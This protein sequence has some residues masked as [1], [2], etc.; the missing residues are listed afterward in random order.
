MACSTQVQ[1]RRGNTADNAGFTGVVGEVTYDTQT[2][3]LFTHD[4]ATVGGF[5]LALFSDV[6]PSTSFLSEGTNLYYTDARARAALSISGPLTY[7]AGTGAF[8]ITLA[9]ATHDGYLS[10]G[11]WS[12]FNSKQAALGFTPE[13]VANKSNDTTL[14]ADS[15]TLYPTQHAVKSYVAANTAVPAGP[16]TAIQF[17]NAG[18]FGGSANLEWTGSLFTVGGGTISLA[19]NGAANFASGGVAIDASANAT[20][21]GVLSDGSGSNWNINPSGVA[22]FGGGG[23]DI[24][25]NGTLTVAGIVLDALTGDLS[26]DN[27][28][29]YEDGSSIFAGVLSFT[30]AGNAGIRLSNLTTVQR[31][32][33]GAPLSGELIWNTTSTAVNVYD[34]SV[35]TTVS[36]GGSSLPVVDTTAIVKGSGDATK[37]VRFEVD[38]FTTA[39]TRVLTPPD[40][41]ITIAGL[42][43]AQTFTK[44][45]TVT[46]AVNTSAIVASGVSLT[47]SNAQNLLDL[48]GTWNTSGAPSGILLT[49]ANTA[50]GVNARLLS[51]NISGTGEV[52]SVIA[53]GSLRINSG[54][55][56][57]GNSGYSAPGF[58]VDSTGAIVTNSGISFTSTNVA[59]VR[60]NNLTTTQRNGLIATTAGRTIWNTTTGAMNVYDGSAWQAITTTQNNPALPVFNYQNFR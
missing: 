57:I 2:H 40:A 32:A 43:V 39:T 48:S 60:L 1:F 20:F 19:P 56:T 7:N 36:G 18:V 16:N 50:S 17:N 45:Q 51:L 52:F 13:N 35:W 47:G 46:P 38:G 31:D 11:N 58:S 9:D 28:I 24:D 14:A 54:N 42:Q 34:G 23:T 10:Q 8:A 55:T 12:T 5:K 4:G 3:R 33:I 27:F 21:N 44:T 6:P 41:D 22:F 37:Q 25:S 29:I 49:I 30:G 15:A 53:D 59:G 26:G